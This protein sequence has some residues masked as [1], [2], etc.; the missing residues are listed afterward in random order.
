MINAPFFQS[1]LASI[2]SEGESFAAAYYFNG[3]S[4]RVS[5]R[6]REE[7]EDVSEIAIKFG[8]GGHKCAAAFNIDSIESFVLKDGD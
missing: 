1:E 7:G 4:Y 6:S 5:L 3:D 8:G 2:L